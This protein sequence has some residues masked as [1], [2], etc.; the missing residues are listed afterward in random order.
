MNKWKIKWTQDN[1][2]R[3]HLKGFLEDSKNCDSKRP[4][5]APTGTP[6]YATARSVCPSTSGTGRGEMW[7][8][9]KSDTERNALIRR[10]REMQT[11][12]RQ[13]SQRI[14]QTRSNTVR[15]K[16]RDVQSNSARSFRVHRSDRS[17]KLGSEHCFTNSPATSFR[18][19]N[20]FSLRSPQ[21]S[22]STRTNM[23]SSTSW[24][25]I[26]FPALTQMSDADMG[27][28]NSQ[29]KKRSIAWGHST[30][31]VAVPN[32]NIFSGHITEKK[33]IPQTLKI[34]QHVDG[35]MAHAKGDGVVSN[36][37]VG[38]KPCGGLY[39]GSFHA[40]YRAA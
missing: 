21:K 38:R 17:P 18:T 27:L 16:E 20:G 2:A 5:S 34:I 4:A 23:N 40:H 29:K 32:K 7:K 6:E 28:Q 33:M 30:T 14:E 22:I 11:E 9:E 8:P 36:P 10:L 25:C 39:A 12:N 3:T 1:D 15:I 24:N 26:P 19:N 13:I 37:G 35:S 31:A